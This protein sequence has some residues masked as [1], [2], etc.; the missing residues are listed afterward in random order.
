MNNYSKIRRYQISVIILMLLSLAIIPR[1]IYILGLKEP[2]YWLRPGAY[3]VY[4]FLPIDLPYVEGG[5]GGDAA[6]YNGLEFPNGTWIAF[7]NMTISWYVLEVYDEYAVVNYSLRLYRVYL[8]ELEEGFL[9]KK[10]YLGDIDL[11]SLRVKIYYNNLSVYD[12]NGSFIGRWPFWLGTRDLYNRT[13]VMVHNVLAHDTVAEFINGTEVLTHMNI[14]I[15]LI[16]L[17]QMAVEAGK[18]PEEE[19]FEIPVGFFSSARLMFANPHMI[20]INESFYIGGG[21]TFPAYYDKVSMVMVAYDGYS[22]IDDMVRYAVGDIYV[23]IRIM[24]DL[25]IT[26]TN[27][28]FKFSPGGEEAPNE[29]GGIGEN[30]SSEGNITLPPIDIGSPQYES[31]STYDFYSIIVAIVLALLLIGVLYAWRK[32][33]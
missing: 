10:S 4:S 3:A 14:T 24:R 20:K 11:V 16:D 1:S 28:D 7:S 29:S 21:P 23:G 27:I 8:A 15:H 22:Y 19:G 26:S 31:G 32:G 18:D 17:A 9:R 12:L 5:S 2:Y 25:A 13:V 6:P 30:I 33:G